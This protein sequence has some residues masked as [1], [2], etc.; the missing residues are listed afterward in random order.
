MVG[1]SGGSAFVLV[2]IFATVFIGVPVMMAEMLLG[3]LTRANPIKAMKQLARQGG[4]TIAWQLLGWWGALALV[5]ILSFYSVVAGWAIAYVVKTWS[6]SLA[7]LTPDQVITCWQQFLNNPLELILWHSIFML[8]T[9]WVV[10]KGVTSGIEKMSK[11]VMPSLFVVLIIL[12]SYSA[13]AGDFAQAVTFLFT[14]DFTKL[15]PSVIRDALGQAVFSLTVGAG[16]MLTYGGYVDDSTKIGLN[17]CIIASLVLLVSLLSG[18]AIFPLVF[19]SGLSPE[20]GPG[21]MFKVLPIAFN[22]MP[23]GTLFGGLFFLMLMCAAWNASISMAETLVVILGDQL[24]LAR[25][26]AAI[27]V[28]IITWSFG[29]LALFSFNILQEVKIFGRYDFFSLME[30]LATHIILPIGALGFAI[31]A[32]WYITPL[33]AKQ[34]LHIHGIWFVLWQYAVKFI[35]PIGILVLAL[36]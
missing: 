7:K 5:L 24:N 12:M 28:G 11:I 36:Y 29:L 25:S 2:L 15:T 1:S 10:A 6:G 35:A 26:R 3:R 22:K 8:A 21:L 9:I 20:C 33:A 34:A 30:E 19:A 32:G 18:L 13:Y 14:P 17:S 23:G 4:H 16:C 27:L 31:F